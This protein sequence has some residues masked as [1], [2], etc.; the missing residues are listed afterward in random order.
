MSQI[1]VEAPTVHKLVKK[2]EL[3]LNELQISP[4]LNNLNST[5]NSKNGSYLFENIDGK[6]LKADEEFIKKVYK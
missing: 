1:P 6:L 5:K 2:N 4:N 3:H